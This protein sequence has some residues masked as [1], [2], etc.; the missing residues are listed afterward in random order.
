M[1]TAEHRHRIATWAGAMLVA[2]CLPLLGPASPAG[3]AGC[4]S[5]V[6]N[7]L[8][9]S[10]CD[11]TTPPE[12]DLS[13]MSPQPSGAG[14]TRTNDVTFTF[15]GIAND[16][17]DTDPVGL[18]CKLEGPSQ[19]HDW[20]D[21]QS[22]RTY[23][24]LA[25]TPS[26]A[27]Y[28]FSVRA[29]DSSDRSITFDDPS[30]PPP[31]FGSDD[32]DVPDQDA[33][34]ETV[35]WK[36]DSFA[37]ITAIFKG[38]YDA[39]GTGWPIVTAPRVTYLIDASE[40]RVTYRCQLDGKNVGCQDGDNTF[41]GLSGGNHVFTATAQDAAGNEDDSPATKQFVVPYNLTR[42]RNWSK[43]AAP[44]YF[45]GDVMQTRQAGGQIKFR[46]QNVREFQLLAP[47]GNEYGKVRVRVGTGYWKTYD[48][49]RPKAAKRHFYEVRDAA[50]PLFSGPILVESLAR[51]K[52]VRVD[53]LVFPPTS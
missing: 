50:S 43:V 27:Q 32:V 19:A 38:P 7:A 52:T 18:E 17:S 51:G 8:P 1:M 14:W 5:E 39:E 28:T 6:P 34:P 42:G 53:A 41:T 44:G 30:T 37:P 11:D 12:T 4:Q 40:S 33:T 31:P 48:L 21:C 35:S 46:A 16:A 49:S 24:D 15:A 9:P 25:D 3:A 47:A 36:Q 26:G 23:T 29:Y 22:P 13:G 20:Q 10:A 2:A 45:G